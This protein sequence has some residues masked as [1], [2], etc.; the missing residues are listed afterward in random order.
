M[1]YL[2]APFWLAVVAGLVLVG[3][4]GCFGVAA[5]AQSDAHALL[6]SAAR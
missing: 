1:K 2:D 5:T 3:S 6:A 4:I